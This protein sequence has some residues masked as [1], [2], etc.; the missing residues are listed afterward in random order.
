MRHSILNC[1]VLVR[2]LEYWWV[3]P[4]GSQS[5]GASLN[6][7]FESTPGYVGVNRVT[8]QHSSLMTVGLYIASTS[9]RVWS[10]I[11]LGEHPRATG[12][13]VLQ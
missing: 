3:G 4:R 1:F 11:R 12:F 6:A 10:L 7:N 9:L 5:P 13:I 2:S 8:P